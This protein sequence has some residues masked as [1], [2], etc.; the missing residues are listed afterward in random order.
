MGK[1][2]CDDPERSLSACGV[3]DKG[4]AVLYPFRH[5]D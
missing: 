5:D 3:L 2:P 4:R 1:P